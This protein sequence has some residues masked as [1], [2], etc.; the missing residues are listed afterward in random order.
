MR[1]T[2]V[3]FTPDQIRQ[4]VKGFEKCEEENR[5]IKKYGSLEAYRDSGDWLPSR[6][7]EYRWARLVRRISPAGMRFP[8]DRENF[9]K[10]RALATYWACVLAGGSVAYEEEQQRIKNVQ[11]EAGRHSDQE[12][13]EIIIDITYAVRRLLKMYR[14]WGNFLIANGLALDISTAFIHNE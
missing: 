8:K 14:E 2:N 4:M 12:S 3:D 13:R 10:D 9:I 5:I 6:D 1:T 7:S 11:K